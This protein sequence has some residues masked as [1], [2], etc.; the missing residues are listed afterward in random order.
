MSLAMALVISSGIANAIPTT[1]EVT[2][3]GQSGS[4]ITLISSASAQ[5]AKDAE[6]MAVK[7][8][9]FALINQGVK[10]LHA[11]QPMLSTPSKQ[12]DYTFYKE[13]KYRNFLTSNPLKI[14]E[15]KI[16]GNKKVDMRV[17]INL[18]RL[19]ENLKQARLSISPA[20]QEKKEVS[21]TVSLN[22][23]IVV[24]PYVRTGNDDSFEGMKELMDTDPAVKYAVNA[25][26]SQFS[27]HGYKTR[28]FVTMLG[29]SK[30]ND[31]MQ[32]GSQTDAKTMI[33]QQMPGDIIVTVDLDLI[34]NGSK[35]QCTVKVDAVEK[36]TAAN[37]CTESF[38]S[39]QFMTTDYISLTDYALKKM[40][41]KFFNQLQDAFAQ[42]VEKGREMKL[43]FTLG[44][45][46]TD[47]D[48]NTESPAT[49]DDFKEELEEWLRSNANHGVYD[50]SRHN[51]KFIEATINIPLWDTDRNRSYSTN[52]F[53]SALKKFLRRQLGDSY[54]PAITS[55]GQQI[56]ITIE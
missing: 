5:K 42:M 26:S 49:E 54:K 32:A 18:D 24:V 4:E 47:W 25:V 38:A 36:Q 11:G 29:N 51:D 10:G 56:L 35:G 50:M 46:V 15:T 3:E 13:G 43:L 12:F 33:L 45:T 21:A 16:A 34:K 1:S 41:G 39:G 40:E 53:S 14:D 6:E 20:W 19:L 31:I 23:T 22:P 9:F 2:L 52:N 28:D 7:Q 48:F 44:E 55:M 27:S 8:A 17:T 37:L 30:T